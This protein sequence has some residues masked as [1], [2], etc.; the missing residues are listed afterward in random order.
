MEQSPSM[1]DVGGFNFS[2]K[3]MERIHNLLIDCS[4]YSANKNIYAWKQNLIEIYKAF[5]PW[6]TKEE[7]R[8][9]LNKLK[10]I[11]KY[12]IV[13]EE[14]NYI[15]D[16][17]LEELLSDFDMWLQYKLFQHK[18][19]FSRSELNRGLMGQY[20]KYGLKQDGKNNS[21]T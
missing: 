18:L 8:T 4:M 1:E 21:D 2:F 14:F 11:N 19:S 3:T 13:I 6:L 15:Y 17:E 20:R 5:Y 7:K 9:A 12:T 16:D 10:K